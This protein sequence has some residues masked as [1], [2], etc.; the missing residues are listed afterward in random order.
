MTTII[1]RLLIQMFKPITSTIHYY[2]TDN[3]YPYII[4][5]TIFI[6]CLYLA[7]VYAPSMNNIHHYVHY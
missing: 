5:L 7:L 6:I 1:G 3:G 2:R 4:K